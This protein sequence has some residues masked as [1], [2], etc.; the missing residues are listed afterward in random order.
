MNN[1]EKHPKENKKR[2]WSN[3]RK[4]LL[5]KIPYILLGYVFYPFI[6]R[7]RVRDKR[8][9]GVSNWYTEQLWFM[10]NDDELSRYGVDWDIKKVKEKGID[11]TTKWGRFKASYW[12]NALRNPAYN[13]SL[14]NGPIYPKGYDNK[15]FEI[16]DVYYQGKLSDPTEWASWL[17]W[18]SEG[19]LNNA[20]IKVSLQ[21]SRVGEGKSWFNPNGD[22]NISYCRY[23]KAKRYKIF[24]YF[25]YLTIQY[26]AWSK[27]Y[28]LNFKLGLKKR[29]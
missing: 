12:F 9:L 7:E 11:T 25:L 21:H 22:S 26:G 20:G 24:N 18:T 16:D 23:S 5:G 17:W 4:A 27:K 15:Y 8:K 2:F 13:Y 28:D 1:S 3:W 6:N 14:S 29:V 10:M 19:R